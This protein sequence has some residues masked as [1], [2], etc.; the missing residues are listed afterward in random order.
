VF[1]IVARIAG[2]RGSII[3]LWRGIAFAISP[4]ILG[5]LGFGAQLVGAALALPFYVRAVAETQSVGIRVG[6][7]AV[8]TPVVLYAAFFVC[9]AAFID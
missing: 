1:W 2:G 6:M 5:V 4:I 7:L 3:A 8:E 9:Y